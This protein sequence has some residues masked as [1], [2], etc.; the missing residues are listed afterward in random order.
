MFKTGQKKVVY[1]SSTTEVHSVQ[2]SGI[3][4]NRNF[5][6]RPRSPG[7]NK[8][9]KSSPPCSCPACGEMHWMADCSFKTKECLEC[10]KVGHKSGFCYSLKN[11]RAKSKRSKPNNN[12][13]TKQV[14]MQ[15]NS[16]NDR[17][18]VQ[19]SIWSINKTAI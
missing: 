3:K 6:S 1:S 8:F 19:T 11:F 4:E 9:A 14:S 5:F 10:K 13:T 12:L 18:F 17:K 15:V 16:V 7:V 2:Q